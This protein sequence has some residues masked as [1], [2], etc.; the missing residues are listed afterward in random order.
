MR[1]VLA[2]ASPARRRLLRSAGIE[3]EVIVSAVDEE[4]L[5]GLW[6]TP[7]EVALG[8]AVAKAGDVARRLTLEGRTLVIGCDSVLEVP[9]VGEL[10]GRALG[11]PADAADACERW[12]LMGGHEGMLH[13]GH[14][15]L[16]LPSGARYVAAATTTVEFAELSPAEIDAY[17]ASGEPLAVAG[18]FTL[19]GR[20]GAFVRRID[21]DPANVIGLSLPLLRDLVGRAGVFWPSLWRTGT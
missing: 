14:C 6:R 21:G 16:D 10:A 4:S 5:A 20:G 9:T 2:S 13:T 3:P 19:D 11:K 17:V 15:V 8:L 18:A 12:R 7:V 1:V